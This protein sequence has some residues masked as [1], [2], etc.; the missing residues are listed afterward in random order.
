[1][2]YED[3]DNSRL[4]MKNQIKQMIRQVFDLELAG[5]KDARELF[6]EEIAGMLIRTD[7]GSFTLFSEERNNEEESLHSKYGAFSES[8][9]KFANPSKLKEKSKSKFD[10]RVLD[11][12]S[13]IG[14]N[15]S[16]IVDLLKDESIELEIDMVESSIETLATTLFIPDLNEAHTYIKKYVEAYL[17][18]KGYLQYNKVLSKIP[19]NLHINIHVVDARDFIKNLSNDMTYD[20]VFLDPFSPDKSPELYSVDFFKQISNHLENNG[21]ILTYSAASAVRSAFVHAGL[22]IGE[23]P[24][25]H[26]SGGTVASKD[27]NMIEKPLSFSDVKMIA[28]S[29]VGI[30]YIDPDLNDDYDA[31]VNRRQEKRE[32]ARFNYLFPSSSKLPLYL[33][34]N[35]EEISDENL[36]NKLNSYV[37]QMGFTSLDDSI[38]LAILDIDKTMPSKDQIISL[39]KQLNDILGL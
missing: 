2:E 29:D 5:H 23:G 38:I 17:I 7:D 13:G 3:E 27:V 20:A 14:Y 31:I 21:L 26:R 9:E 4:E 35:P 37:Q 1:M 12:C 6:K 28:L 19:S 30:P 32:K 39:Q 10:I 11:I 24:E 36:R 34:V 15:A 33:G 8:Y 22:N 16:A 25:F 18:E